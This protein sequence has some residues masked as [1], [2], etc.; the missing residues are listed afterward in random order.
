[1]ALQYTSKELKSDREI[2]LAAVKQNG[3]ALEYASEEL[4]ND[5]EILLAT[6]QKSGQVLKH[7]SVDASQIDI[8]RYLREDNSI[9]EGQ[10]TVVIG[11]EAAEKHGQS[12]SEKFGGD[13]MQPVTSVQ[14][15]V[16]FGQFDD[17]IDYS[18][19]DWTIDF[20]F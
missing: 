14:S 7:A 5:R 20:Q 3:G 18:D 19:Y 13:K 15:E 9:I 8:G 4:K 16:N 6:V 1:W 2:V 12:I 10:R 11:D 17:Y